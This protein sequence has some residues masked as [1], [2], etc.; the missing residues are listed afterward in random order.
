ME[1]LGEMGKGGK[2]GVILGR[3]GD[4]EETRRK[5]GR[6]WKAGERMGDC[7]GKAGNGEV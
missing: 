4:I 1:K 7:V 3:F 2:V 5:W 6:V